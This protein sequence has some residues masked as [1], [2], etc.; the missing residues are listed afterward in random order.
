[1]VLIKNEKVH[2]NMTSFGF[3][4]SFIFKLPFLIKKAKLYPKPIIFPASVRKYDTP[5]YSHVNNKC[6]YF[7]IDSNTTMTA[8][9]PERDLLAPVLTPNEHLDS[10]VFIG[11]TRAKVVTGARRR[12]RRLRLR[13]AVDG[14][15]SSRKALTAAALFL[16]ILDWHLDCRNP[17]VKLV[18]GQGSNTT[19]LGTLHCYKNIASPFSLF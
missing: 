19:A 4:F 6:V 11:L 18:L 2:S 3:I 1:M 15:R 14:R 9:P 12:A 5:L 17:C 16:D 10:N 8:A 13:G 7:F